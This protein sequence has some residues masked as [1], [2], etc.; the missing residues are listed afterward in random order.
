MACR[1]YRCCC[2][3]WGL[4]K[5]SLVMF[6]YQIA[7]CLLFT[8]IE[9]NFNAIEC[10]RNAPVVNETT[11]ARLFLDQLARK[12]NETLTEQQ[13]TAMK[14]LFM[15]H[16]NVSLQPSIGVNDWSRIN[17]CLKW[18]HFSAM[19]ITTIGKAFFQFL[20]FS[21]LLSLLSWTVSNIYI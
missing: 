18:Y 19:T 20:S 5:G 17:E 6:M 10:F 8:Y 2:Q 9:D 4:L 13:A 15:E 21:P 16:F 14:L 3:F 7:G 1:R 12:T 11:H